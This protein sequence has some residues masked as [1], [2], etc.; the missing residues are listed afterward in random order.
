MQS[1]E[2]T[3]TIT[4]SDI[5]AQIPV[6][7]CKVYHVGDDV[8]VYCNNTDNTTI[9]LPTVEA[10]HDIFQIFAKPPKFMNLT[11]CHMGGKFTIPDGTEQV[12]FVNTTI[13]GDV[14]IPNGCIAIYNGCNEIGKE[15]HN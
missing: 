7:E 15:V 10:K 4:H 12:S 5:L 9:T 8:Y 3:T 13:K 6:G 14:I 1:V 2:P 11:N